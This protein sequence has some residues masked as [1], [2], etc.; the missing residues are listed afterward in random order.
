MF[1]FLLLGILNLVIAVFSIFFVPEGFIKPLLRWILKCLYE[2]KLHGF[3]HYTVAGDSVVIVAN[4]TSLL[5]VVLLYAFLP[6]DLLFAINRFTAHIWWVRPFLYFAKVF[7][8]DPLNPLAIK[9]LIREVKK[10]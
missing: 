3:E 1:L 2:V 8:L 4:H 10:P 6:D 9:A 7:E 5:D